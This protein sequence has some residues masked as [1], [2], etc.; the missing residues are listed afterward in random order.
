MT[1]SKGLTLVEVLAAVVITTGTI[2]GFL[3]IMGENLK[4]SRETE[5]R[6]ISSLL[7]E[8]DLE[9]MKAKLHGGLPTGDGDRSLA[10][11]YRVIS[12]VTPVSSRD[13][14][15]QITVRV[16]YDTNGDGTLDNEEIL[17][18]LDTQYAER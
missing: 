8:G 12:S 6:T 7:A 18:T 10:N 3:N 2:L 11:G 14:L 9:Q 4:A 15:N 1:A 16:G 13:Y 17:V 5:L